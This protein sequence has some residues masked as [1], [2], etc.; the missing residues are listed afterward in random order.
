MDSTISCQQQ[1]F[2]RFR[3]SYWPA[4]G[5]IEIREFMARYVDQV[6]NL[7]DLEA[8]FADPT[9]SQQH[10]QVKLSCNCCTCC[11][12]DCDAF[13]WIT[14]SQCMECTQLDRQILTR[15]VAEY[16]VWADLSQTVVTDLPRHHIPQLVFSTSVSPSHAHCSCMDA[17]YLHICPSPLWLM[18]IELAGCNY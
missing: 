16:Y 2:G 13:S 18:M 15:Q 8:A 17:A 1:S 7:D 9:H 6:P 5:L 4:A 3:I 14:L 12:I 10:M 11:D